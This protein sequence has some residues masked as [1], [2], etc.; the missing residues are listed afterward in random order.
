MHFAG[1]STPVRAHISHKCIVLGCWMFLYASNSIVNSS[2][3]QFC[4]AI[5][6]WIS[7]NSNGV[8]GKS[9]KNS[10]LGFLVLVVVDAPISRAPHLKVKKVVFSLGS[11]CCAFYG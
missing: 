5:R 4:C 9:S 8:W 10:R 11:S 2:E 1:I 3:M 7:H 6:I